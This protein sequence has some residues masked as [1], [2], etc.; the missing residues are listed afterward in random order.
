MNSLKLYMSLALALYVGIVAVAKESD[1]P[2]ARQRIYNAT[3]VILAFLAFSA[4]MNGGMAEFPRIFPLA[5]AM[6]LTFAS[7]ATLGKRVMSYDRIMTN[8]GPFI[9]MI[10]SLYAII[11]RFEDFSRHLDIILGVT[12]ALPLIYA[13]PYFVGKS[14]DMP[15]ALYDEAYEASR[16]AYRTTTPPGGADE[17][18]YV[19]NVETG[20]RCGVFSSPNRIVIAF[21]GSDSKLDWLRTNL[22]GAVDKDT[23]VHT[24]FLTAWRSIKDRVLTVA[25]DMIIRNGG[26]KAVTLLVTGH[27]QGGAL[28][29]VSAVDIK[30]TLDRPM[31]V[32]TFA[33]PPVGD[34]RFIK[35]FD[36]ANFDAWRV[37]TV[38]D[39]IPKLVVGTLEHPGKSKK[40]VIASPGAT[41]FTAHDISFYERK[42]QGK[43]RALCIQAMVLL[44]ILLFFNYK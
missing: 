15:V 9:V 34:A 38:H 25:G 14:V 5:V 19:Q 31:T 21:S 10:L 16:A 4:W 35:E 8:A 43:L 18:E 28:A 17:Y 27:S 42:D 30:N 1:T 2:K 7:Y 37:F 6:A 29:T 33:A 12:F 23:G 32:V 26:G 24:G 20:A 3:S 36:A 22:D 13:T 39:P 40:V 11:P 41:A 44:L